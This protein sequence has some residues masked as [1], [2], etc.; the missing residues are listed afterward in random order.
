[1]GKQQAGR[2]KLWNNPTTKTTPLLFSPSRHTNARAALL[3]AI[4]EVVCAAR[5]GLA[6]PQ[7]LRRTIGL[8]RRRRG[9]RAREREKQRVTPP[10]FLSRKRGIHPPS[11]TGKRTAHTSSLVRLPGRRGP[12][13][14]TRDSTDRPTGRAA[15]LTPPDTAARGNNCAVARARARACGGALSLSRKE[16]EQ[17]RG[18]QPPTP[19]NPQQQHR[20]GRLLQHAPGR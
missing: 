1:M 20:N 10:A 7:P 13:E 16:Q 17:R 15:L 19:A 5:T 4:Q 8:H 14:R 2:I 6:P 3:L 12:R 11:A 18:R 9:A